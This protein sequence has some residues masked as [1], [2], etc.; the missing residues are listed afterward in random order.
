MQEFALEPSEYS[1]SNLHFICPQNLGCDF[2]NNLHISLI[3]CTYFI[4]YYAAMNHFKEVSCLRGSTNEKKTCGKNLNLGRIRRFQSPNLCRF[5]YRNG[6]I[7]NWLP[8]SGKVNSLILLYLKI[9]QLSLWLGLGKK[10][11][12][13]KWS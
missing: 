10:I 8:K 12:Y 9:R 1:N 5:P 13:R 7:Q 2:L 6:K 3:H 11:K 4:Y